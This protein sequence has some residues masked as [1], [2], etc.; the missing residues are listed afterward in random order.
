MRYERF[1]GCRCSRRHFIVATATAAAG[2]LLA[3]CGG[4]GSRV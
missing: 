1:P 4:G 2:S 3:G